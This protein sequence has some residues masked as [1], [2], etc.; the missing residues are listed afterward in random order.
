M[1]HAAPLA[2]RALGG[3]CLAVALAL[4]ACRSDEGTAR[5]VAERFLDAHYVHVDLP[6]SRPYTSGLARHK[7]DEEIRLTAGQAVDAGTRV[8]RVHYRLL[9]ERSRDADTVSFAYEAS[10]HVEEA[11]S[12]QRT[13]QLTVRRGA[14]GWKVSNYQ[15]Y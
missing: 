9:D 4:G 1:S 13:I 15:E 2:R 7:I 3:G 10:I 8:P 5:G 6:A 12:F 14:E 11:E